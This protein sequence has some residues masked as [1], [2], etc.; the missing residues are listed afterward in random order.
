MT[1]T[2]TDNLL[3]VQASLEVHHTENW[4]KYS[5]QVQVKSKV[6]KTL[7]FGFDFE[8]YSWIKLDNNPISV[9][10]VPCKLIFPKP[11]N[12]I[13]FFG[14]LQFKKQTQQQ[15]KTIFLIQILD[16][17][18]IC[19]LIGKERCCEI[20]SIKNQILPIRIRPKRWRNSSG[21]AATFYLT[22]FFFWCFKPLYSVGQTIECF[23]FFFI[24]SG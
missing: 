2:A 5:Y 20:V 15:L 24:Q 8:I 14:D 11:L 7:N 3:I 22:F 13:A 23:V 4:L 21:N 17:H 18:P 6:T 1:L 10:N 16:A 12:K 9:G 19:D